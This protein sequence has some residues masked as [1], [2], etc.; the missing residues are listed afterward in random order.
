MIEKCN[1]FQTVRDLL[2]I[3]LNQALLR[4]W[5][6]G[7]TYFTYLQP[8]ST[9]SGAF[10]VHIGK[11]NSTYDRKYHSAEELRHKRRV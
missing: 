10:L 2:R 8:I 11:C 5:M 1:F 9:L 3:K 4:S 7:S 6:A